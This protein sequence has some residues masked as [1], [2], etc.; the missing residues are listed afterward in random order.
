MQNFSLVPY[1][2]AVQNALFP[3]ILNGYSK[4]EQYDLATNALKTV[5]LDNRMNHFPHE[6]SAG[7][8]QRVA[9]ARAM[10]NKPALIFA[11]EPTGNLDPAL[12]TEIL[13]ML[14]HI[15]RRESITIIMVTHSREAAGFG[16]V[17]IQLKDGAIEDIQV[18]P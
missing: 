9:I 14:Q 11:D 6:L 16:N 13:E 1:M 2:T 15:N 12:A 7:Q 17:T 3:L 18:T 10:V 5:G 8:Q 4:K